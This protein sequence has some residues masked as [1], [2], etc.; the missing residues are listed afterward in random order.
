MACNDTG[1]G[2]VENRT[3]NFQH[4]NYILQNFANFT[5]EECKK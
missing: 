1:I 3:A 4:K 5:L 2:E